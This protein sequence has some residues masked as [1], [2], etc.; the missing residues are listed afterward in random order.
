MDRHRRRQQPDQTFDAANG[1]LA[2]ELSGHSATIRG[3]TFSS[4]SSRV[5]SASADKTVHI[6][7]ISGDAIKTLTLP[8][9]VNAVAWAGEGKRLAAAGA[10]GLIRI[11]AV[12]DGAGS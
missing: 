1:T 4:D 6:W 9:E 11:W 2:R 3:L 10:D 12:P 5:A 8:A 7:N